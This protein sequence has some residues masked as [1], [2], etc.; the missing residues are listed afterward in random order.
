MSPSG[1]G[2]LIKQAKMAQLNAIKED[3]EAESQLLKVRTRS[4][5][6]NTALINLLSS[7]V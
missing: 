6:F 7:S 2:V 5:E 1:D 4:C 3:L